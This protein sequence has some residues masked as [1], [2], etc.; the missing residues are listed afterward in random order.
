MSLE[1]VFDYLQILSR[2]QAAARNE[3]SK[4]DSSVVQVGLYIVELPLRVLL[5]RL[6]LTYPTQII[7]YVT[8]YL[9]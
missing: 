1:D 9:Y 6:N 8:L 7:V 4:K 5:I 2:F 3:E